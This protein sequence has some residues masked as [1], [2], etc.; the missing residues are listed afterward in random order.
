MTPLLLL[1][2]TYYLLPTTCYLLPTTTY[3]YRLTYYYLLPTT[4]YLLPTYYLL[5]CYLLLLT[6]TPPDHAERGRSWRL[7][8]VPTFVAGGVPVRDFRQIIAGTEVGRSPPPAGRGWCPSRPAPG[9]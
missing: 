7:R 1:P 4:S 8:A 9:F 5:S 6:P 3:H 2:T